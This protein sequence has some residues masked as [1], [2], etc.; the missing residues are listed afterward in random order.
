MLEAFAK[1]KAEQPN[2]LLML[3]PRHPDRVP[4][5]L[6]MPAMRRYQVVRHIAPQRRAGATPD[7]GAATGISLA[8]EDDVLVIYPLGQLLALTGCADAVFVGGSLIPHGGHNPLEAAAWF[9]PIISGPHPLISPVLTVT[10]SRL[11]QR[12]R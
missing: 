5:I 2:A 9:L 10:C 1:L 7:A 6:A 11:M 12:L 8:F 4:S 3:A